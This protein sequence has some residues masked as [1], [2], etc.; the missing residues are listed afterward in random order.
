MHGPL[1]AAGCVGLGLGKEKNTGNA[2]GLL[3]HPEYQERTT[4]LGSKPVQLGSPVRPK[5]A[6]AQGARCR[7]TVALHKYF[8]LWHQH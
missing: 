7:W 4:E 1:E 8:A 2:P 6:E 3:V 5:L